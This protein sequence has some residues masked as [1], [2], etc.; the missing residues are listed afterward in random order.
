MTEG[1]HALKAQGCGTEDE[2]VGAIVGGK[3]GPFRVEL[4]AGFSSSLP[5]G[6]TARPAVPDDPECLRVDLITEPSLISDWNRVNHDA[7]RIKPGDII[8]QVNGVSGNASGML[9]EILTAGLSPDYSELVLEVW[10]KAMRKLRNLKEQPLIEQHH[11][12]REGSSQNVLRMSPVS[13]SNPL[14]VPAAHLKSV[15]QQQQQ[16]QQQTNQVSR[17]RHWEGP[18]FTRPMEKKERSQPAY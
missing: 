2:D 6:I 3:I 10:P 17:S 15:Q 14:G 4:F 18:I 13:R 8:S 5:L 7:V 12:L 1:F 11:V 16:Q 9:D